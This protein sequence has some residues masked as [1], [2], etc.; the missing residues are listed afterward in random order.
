MNCRIIKDLLPLYVEQLTSDPS[1]D[2]IQEHIK[3]CQDCSW[4]LAGLRNDVII[5]S[6]SQADSPADAVPLQLVKRIKTRILE[7]IIVLASVA[8]VGGMLIGIL[9]SSPL[10][11]MVL[12]ASTSLM[13]FAVAILL[14]IAV[15]RRTSPRKR[16]QM[17]GN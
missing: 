14:S 10:R 8:F 3:T 4:T 7:K 6:P 2:L 15:C 16:F 13:V 1:N 17:V 9:S 11:F 12:M 5:A